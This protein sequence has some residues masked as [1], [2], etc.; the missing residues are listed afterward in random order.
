MMITSLCNS[1]CKAT[2]AAVLPY[3]SPIWVRVGLDQVPPDKHHNP[4]AAFPRHCLTL[5]SS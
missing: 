1:Q 4:V 3:F 2:C 5:S